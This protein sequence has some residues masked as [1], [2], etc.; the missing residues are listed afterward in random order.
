MNTKSIM[1]KFL[2]TVIMA[3]PMATFAEEMM[4]TP[5]IIGS[6]TYLSGGVGET[7]SEMMKGVAKDYPLEVVFVQRENGQEVFLSDILIQIEDSHKNVVVETT[8]EGPYFFANLPSGKYLVTAE[9]NGEAK[10]HRVNVN[11]K[12]HQ[13]IVFWWPALEETHE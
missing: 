12:K 8:A 1:I 3:L 4:P 9:H 6:I 10:H 13:R 11:V 5:K 2:L 7:E